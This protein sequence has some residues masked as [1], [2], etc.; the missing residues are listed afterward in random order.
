[1]ILRLIFLAVLTMSLTGCW[2]VYVPGSAM[3]AIS[4]GVTGSFGNA[5]VGSNAKEGGKV[6]TPGGGT[7]TVD[8]ISGP[9]SRCKEP[10]PIRA[11]VTYD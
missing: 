8:K 1:M 5:C 2:F 7:A 4:D 6:R 11:A 3:E 9:S 10:T